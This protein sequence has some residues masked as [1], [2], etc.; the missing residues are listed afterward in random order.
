MQVNREVSISIVDVV[1]GEDAASGS[2]ADFQVMI[3]GEL[4]R[5]R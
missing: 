1:L 3:R 4:Y 5:A 2:V